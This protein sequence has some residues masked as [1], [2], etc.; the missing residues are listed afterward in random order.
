MGRRVVALLA[1]LA[2]LPGMA[3]SQAG[4]TDAP[5][6]KPIA[7]IPA[8]P[9]AP[10]EAVTAFRRLLAVH[11][12][13]PIDSNTLARA[14]TMQD[15]LALVRTDPFTDV[16]SPARWQSFAVALGQS[17]GGIG[18]VLGR[19]RDTLVL[20]D[21][22]PD[23]PASEAGLE[24]RDRIVSID[25]SAIVGWSLS[26]A[27]SRIRGAPGSTV[28]LGIVRRGEAKTLIRVLRAS[29]QSPSVPA[30]SLSPNGL[31]IITL[32]Q[33]GPDL[34]ANLVQTIDRMRAHGLKSLILDLRGN[35]GGL[36]EEAIRVSNLFLP[37]GS[38][39]VETRYRG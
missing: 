30:A 35:P 7:V 33:F 21:V 14:A 10:P 4:T 31:G 39:L 27:V 20:G 26:H 19:I 29:V 5:A 13:T 23:G 37:Q 28:S 15:L 34:S 8:A 25:D 9:P 1:T 12:V 32:S 38:L 18:A 11:Y 36:L 3:W 22:L 24:I 17:F 6:A 16:Y 2:L